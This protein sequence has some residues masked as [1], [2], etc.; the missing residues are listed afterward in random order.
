[1]EKHPRLG[2]RIGVLA[3]RHRKET[4][5]APLLEQGLGL[6]VS[7]PPDFDTDRFGTFSREI[8]RPGDQH[9]TARLKIQQALALT[10]ESLGVASEGSF[11][12]HPFFP[13]LAVNREL[14]MLVDTTQDLEISGLS[15]STDTNYA[16]EQVEDW[17]QALS[18]AQKVGFPEH[19]LIAMPG[20]VAHSSS[21]PPQEWIFKGITTEAA[22]QDA[23]SRLFQHG[24]G[25]HLE[26]DM[27][28]LYNPTRMKNIAKATENLIEKLSQTCPQCE[29]PGYDVVEQKPGLPCGVCGQPTALVQ[30]FIWQC[31][32]CH[33]QEESFFPHGK[34][35]NPAQ[36]HYCNP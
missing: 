25:V 18:F 17:S 27:R 2:N 12:P 30:S 13:M 7:V 21:K 22:L 36:C 19:G 32:R 6:R 4:V 28:A 3:T 14:V 23:L 10:G 9:H 24:N 5:M 33:F 11:G 15:V 29:W 35:A 31:Q 26:T 16:H 1:M 8:E 20:G 34:T